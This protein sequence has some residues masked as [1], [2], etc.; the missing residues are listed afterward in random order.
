MRSLRIA[1]V[2]AAL[3]VG[4][5]FS[6]IGQPEAAVSA[7][8]DTTRSITVSGTGTADGEPN[9]ADFTFGVVTDGRTARA[10]LAANAAEARRVIAALREAGVAE[11]DIQTQQ[12]S[13]MLVF[14][15]DARTV[16]GY[17]A[18]NSVT[19]RLRDLARAGAAIDAA[20][21]AGANEVYGPNLIQSD[22]ATIERQALAAAMADARAKAQAVAAAGGVALGRVLTVVEGG[23][24]APPIPY[25][26]D[27]R[28][29]VAE[30]STP[31][32]PGTQ[33]IQAN[34]TVTYA[35]S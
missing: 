2:A 16:T 7:A 21:E 19:A 25:A 6:G 33:E 18:R 23:G 15:D 35:V 28:T 8:G 30:S 1:L 22:R 20:V 14:T 5:A 11:R 24:V 26:A 9:R 10:A 17:Q 27:A 3:L 13:I 31:V 32:S 29:A 4:A 12:V 34:V